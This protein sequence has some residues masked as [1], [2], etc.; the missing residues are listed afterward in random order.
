MAQVAT[1]SA[2]GQRRRTESSASARSVWIVALNFKVGGGIDQ[3]TTRITHR[4]DI[5]HINVTAQAGAQQRVES[6]VHGHNV[7]ALPR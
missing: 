1:T 7:I 4:V 6:A 5:P 3:R 2:P